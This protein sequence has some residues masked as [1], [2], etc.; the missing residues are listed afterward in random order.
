MEIKNESELR[1]ADQQES[2]KL[3]N[4]FQFEC[5]KGIKC[6]NQCCAD[7]N[8]V[9]T[10]YDVL[11]MKNRLGITSDEFL[12]NYTGIIR[13]EKSIFPIVVL[14][15]KDDEHKQC[16]FVSEEGCQIY[17]DRPW[18]CRMFPLDKK[19]SPGDE[20]TFTLLKKL[21]C[22]GFEEEKV[23]KV[24]DWVLSQGINI[25]EKHESLYQDITDHERAKDLDITNPDVFLML[26]MALYDLDKFRKFVLESNFLNYFDVEQGRVE[27]IRNDDTELL[28]FGIEWIKFGLLGQQT[29]CVKEK[30][31]NEKKKELE[32]K[33][34]LKQSPP[35]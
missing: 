26:Q 23:W 18:A 3:S 10:P 30:V 20:T 17:E 1:E 28:T 2:L 4:F 29:F 8:I 14:K 9:L 15:M 16:F 13:S 31:A 34:L 5:R 19:E 6:F 27:T 32:K 21:D 22:L 25:Y 11:R 33:G 35:D 12:K 7:V 24:E